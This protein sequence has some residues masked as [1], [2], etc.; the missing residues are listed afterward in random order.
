[1]KLTGSGEELRPV[2]KSLEKK[3]SGIRILLDSAFIN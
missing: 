1:M 2:K 3:L